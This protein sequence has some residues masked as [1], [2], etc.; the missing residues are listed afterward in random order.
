MT[1]L[2]LSQS[3]KEAFDVAAEAA[4]QAGEILKTHF[5]GER[6]VRYKGRANIVTDIDLRADNAIKSLQ[7]LPWPQLIIRSI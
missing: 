4:R 1:G 3:G 5:R 7:Y 6:Q 2:P